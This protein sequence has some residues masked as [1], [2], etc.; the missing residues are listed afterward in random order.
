MVKMED[1]HLQRLQKGKKCL[2]FRQSNILIISTFIF[3]LLIFSPQPPTTSNSATTQQNNQMPAPQSLLQLMPHTPQPQMSPS[4]A[5]ALMSPD[6][7]YFY[8]NQS[9]YYATAPYPYQGAGPRDIYPYQ[10]GSTYVPG[11]QQYQWPM[12]NIN[13][14]PNVSLFKVRLNKIFFSYL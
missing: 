7:A 12:T 3:K 14:M 8:M 2:K 10:Y 9:G 4:N 5:G 6:S 1:I 11:A 13:F